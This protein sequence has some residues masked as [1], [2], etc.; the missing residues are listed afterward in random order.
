[1]TIVT[2]FMMGIVNITVETVSNEPYIRLHDEETVE[3]WTSSGFYSETGNV[4]WNLD[5]KE[6]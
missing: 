1:M 3:K 5:T 4:V 2:M 6:S